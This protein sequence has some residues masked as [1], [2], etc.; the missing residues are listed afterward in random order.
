[1]S[2]ITIGPPT[3]NGDLHLGHL[4]GPYT[5]ADIAARFLRSRR[6]TPVRLITATDDH[7]SYVQL[8][9]MQRNTTPE[10][11]VDEFNPAIAKTLEC[12]GIEL[13]YYGNPYRS[14]TYNVFIQSVVG[15]LAR[16]GMIEIA[17]TPHLWCE[18]CLQ[19]GAE[20]FVHGKCK[21]CGN[22]ADGGI[23]EDCGRPNVSY[24]LV[25]P[26]CALCGLA[27]VVRRSQ[28]AVFPLE[29]SRKIIET[30]LATYAM[31]HKM[32]ALCESVL[33]APLPEVGVS[34]GFT[35]GI[36]LKLEELPDRT[37]SAWF[38][39]GPHYLA[40]TQEMCS[41]T[42]E[43][44]WMEYW[45]R[46]AEVIQ[47]FG[48]D[49]CYFHAILFPAIYAA[50]DVG[51]APRLSFVINEF[52]E[53]EHRKFSTSRSHAIWGSEF[54]PKA[55]ADAVRTYL[56]LTRP[57]VERTNFSL[58]CFHGFVD[59]E[60]SS[61][62]DWLQRVFKFVGVERSVP[63]NS[64]VHWLNRYAEAR[65]LIASAIETI[66][67]CYSPVTFSLQ[68]AVRCLQD[69]VFE[70][71]MF[72][73]RESASAH[74]ADSSFSRIIS[75]RLNHLG[76]AAFSVMVAPIAPRFAASLWECISRERTPN[77]AQFQFES[78]DDCEFEIRSMTKM[79]L[80][81]RSQVD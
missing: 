76:L 69:F 12:T 75:V 16:R 32:A 8:R 59:Q 54:L 29:K 80:P 35:W 64:S 49:S 46:G 28:A 57:E 50:M 40:I 58:R 68:R 33:S 52:Y 77:L 67:S 66:A 3:S 13:D 20:A 48:F 31:N 65:S 63:I 23:C 78:V 81:T 44:T 37:I 19:F 22:K 14:E 18:R 73:A 30:R 2:L 26:C 36:P 45:C 11:V 43:K 42:R 7:Q 24:D 62:N 39:L 1:M 6:G 79:E 10:S 27:L 17:E 25:E 74:Y 5:A 60:L 47:F 70:M 4:A 61:W 9:A 53:L 41:A 21:Y 15:D 34:L 56:A 71:M 38:E 51:I 55:G 72:V